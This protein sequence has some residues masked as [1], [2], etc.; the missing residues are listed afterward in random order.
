M[1]R[2]HVGAAGCVVGS[3]GVGCA[4]GIVSVSS[5]NSNPPP[6]AGCCHASHQTRKAARA[7]C[8][9]ACW[10]A[11]LRCC[12]VAAW[13]GTGAGAMHTCSVRAVAHAGLGAVRVSRPGVLLAGVVTAVPSAMSV[14][15]APV[16]ALQ[17]EAALAQ[18]LSL[19]GTYG[20]AQHAVVIDG[21]LV[22]LDTAPVVGAAA[23]NAGVPRL[24]GAVHTLVAAPG[25][26][27]TGGCTGPAWCGVESLMAIISPKPGLCSSP[28]LAWPPVGWGRSLS[29]RGAVSEIPCHVFRPMVAMIGTLKE[30][31]HW[32]CRPEQCPARCRYWPVAVA[33]WAVGRRSAGPPEVI[34]LRVEWHRGTHSAEREGPEC[35]A[36]EILLSVFGLMGTLVALRQ[37]ENF[38]IVRWIERPQDVALTRG[39]CMALGL[40]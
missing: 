7:R 37:D 17:G 40:R 25:R 22:A 18:R 6:F 10:S 20:A 2:S 30:G 19:E 11:T 33:P 16:L 36:D 35:I 14:C 39:V 9:W 27:C 29:C 5:W 15:V 3:T 32:H 34:R 23:E 4:V 24:P 13:L 38:H 12:C 8:A 1:H 31:R 21:R 28:A 26:L